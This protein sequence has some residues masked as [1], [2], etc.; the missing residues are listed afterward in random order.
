[1]ADSWRVYALELSSFDQDLKTR[2]HELSPLVQTGETCA[3]VAYS[4]SLESMRR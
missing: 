1:M 4:S 2:D 3:N